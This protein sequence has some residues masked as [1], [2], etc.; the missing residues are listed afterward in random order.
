[1]SRS[2]PRAQS[3]VSSPA[4]RAVRRH[5][6]AVRRPIL[7]LAARAVGHLLP[8]RARSPPSPPQP[9][10]VCRLVPSR[11]RSPPPTARSPSSRPQ[12]SSAPCYANRHPLPR[13]LIAS[14]TQLR[15][16]LEPPPITARPANIRPQPAPHFYWSEADRTGTSQAEKRRRGYGTAVRSQA[17]FMS[18]YLLV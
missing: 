3:A 5:P 13:A 15:A 2:Q 11:A 12:P 7:S 16:L 4:A 8:S 9:R 14:S 17:S 18:P 10:A 1:M 6:R